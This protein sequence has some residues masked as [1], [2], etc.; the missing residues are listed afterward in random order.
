MAKAK[1]RQLNA[2]VSLKDGTKLKLKGDAAQSALSQYN[3]YALGVSAAQALTYTDTDGVRKSLSFDCICGVNMLAPT[4]T[5]EPIEDC[6][7]KDC[8][9]QYGFQEVEV[10]A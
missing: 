10:P 5:D 7:R 9:Y 4:I 8:A 2:E 3:S 1:K 6:D